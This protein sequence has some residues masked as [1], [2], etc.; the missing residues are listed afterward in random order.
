M[1]MHVTAQAEV[2]KN[3]AL[4]YVDAQAMSVGTWTDE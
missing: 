2:L 1:M 3:P 4:L